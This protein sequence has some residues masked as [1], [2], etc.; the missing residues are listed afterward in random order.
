MNFIN[1]KLIHLA[2]DTSVIIQ[3]YG[4]IKNKLNDMWQDKN[5]PWKL[6]D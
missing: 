5:A 6:W 2:A 3:A 1:D 4:I